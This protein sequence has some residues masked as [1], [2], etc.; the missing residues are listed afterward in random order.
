MAIVVRPRDGEADL[1]GEAA[2]WQWGDGDGGVVGGGNGAHDRQAETVVPVISSGT[3]AESMER[4][5]QP[6]DLR[7]WDEGPGIGYG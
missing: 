5:K 4:L 3:V 2:L 1:D 6:L 7:R